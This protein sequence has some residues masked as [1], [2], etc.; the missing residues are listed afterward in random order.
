MTQHEFTESFQLQ[1]DL[2]QQNALTTWVEYLNFEYFWFDWFSNAVQRLKPD[3]DKVWQKLINSKMLKSHEIETFLR[4][5]RS[6]NQFNA[7]KKHAWKAVEKATSK[8]KQIYTLT[9]SDSW[10]MN[11]LQQIHIRLLRAAKRVLLAAKI[12][13]TSV[14]KRTDLVFEFICETNKYNSMIQNE[15][16][17]R[18]FLLWILNQVF[19]LHIELIQFKT[20]AFSLR[21]K[22]IKKNLMLMTIAWKNKISKNKNFIIEKLAYL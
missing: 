10:R 8:I 2:M 9:Q 19:L 11:I 15:S 5:F 4:I 13:L 7:D 21:I 20:T 14:K 16:R 3:C 22:N 12:R 6:L 17:L 18:L 1:K